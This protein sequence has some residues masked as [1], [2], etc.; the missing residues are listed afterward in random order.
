MEIGCWIHSDSLPSK[1]PIIQDTPRYV[2]RRPFTGVKSVKRSWLVEMNCGILFL[3]DNCPGEKEVGD[4][5]PDQLLGI[6]PVVFDS[7]VQFD[8]SSGQWRMACCTVVVYSPRETHWRFQ[9]GQR[10]Y[11]VTVA[12]GGWPVL[13]FDYMA[14]VTGGWRCQQCVCSWGVHSWSRQTDVCYIHTKHITHKTVFC[15]GE[16]WILC[17]SKWSTKVSCAVTV[18]WVK[19]CMWGVYAV[20]RLKCVLPAWIGAVLICQVYQILFTITG[21]NMC[22][23]L[24]DWHLVSKVAQ[25]SLA[26]K[27]AMTRRRVCHYR[28]RH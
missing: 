27:G 5:M 10:G 7:Y 26:T 23:L 2:H 22:A 9:D 21:Y 17:P 12:V 16:M 4:S 1:H 11:V 18:Y 13:C 8:Y 14:A 19:S 3:L 25:D 20:T 6:F 24:L 28:C 15:G